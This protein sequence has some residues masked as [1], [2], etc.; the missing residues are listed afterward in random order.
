MPSTQ[1]KLKVAKLFNI[2]LELLNTL[3]KKNIKSISKYFIGKLI[4]DRS[5]R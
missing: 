3:F 4:K 5:H 1:N 2:E